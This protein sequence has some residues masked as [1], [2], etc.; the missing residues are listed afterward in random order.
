MADLREGC[1]ILTVAN[2]FV[3]QSIPL[4]TWMESCFQAYFKCHHS[5]YIFA[6]PWGSKPS[7]SSWFLLHWKLDKIK[8]GIAVWQLA[9]Q[10]WKVLGTFKKLGRTWNKGKWIQPQ[11]SHHS[12][13]LFVSINNARVYVYLH[14]WNNTKPMFSLTLRE[15]DQSWNV[16]LMFSYNRSYE[17]QTSYSNGNV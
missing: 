12:F 11:Y 3:M 15:T 2:C 6:T 5:F 14:E 17:Q 10:A 4:I 8:K 13:T 7:K 1:A 16:T 9:V